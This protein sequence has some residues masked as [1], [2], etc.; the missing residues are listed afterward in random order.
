MRN[1]FP[2]FL[3]LR[4]QLIESVGNYGQKFIHRL[5]LLFDRFQQWMQIFAWRLLLG[6]V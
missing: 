2:S 5:E 4:F 6:G 1:V 3:E